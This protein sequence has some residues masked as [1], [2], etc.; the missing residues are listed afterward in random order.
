[1]TEANLSL[2]NVKLKKDALIKLKM[3]ISIELGEIRNLY[4][5]NLYYKNT[6]KG[7]MAQDW[8]SACRDYNTGTSYHS[9]SSEKRSMA[10][11]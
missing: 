3:P 9:V 5:S 4:V 6:D 8:K 1:M 10:I 11:H 2:N 7:S